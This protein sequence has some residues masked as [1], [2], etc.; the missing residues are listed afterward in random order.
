[1]TGAKR[2]AAPT[3]LK[4]RGRRFWTAAVE[5]YEFTDAE[6]ELLVEVCRTLD[7]TEQLD[8]VVRTDGLTIEGSR[9]QTVTHP[10][11][12][13]LRQARGLLSRLLAQLDLPDVDGAASLPSAFT[14]RARQGASARWGARDAG[15]A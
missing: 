11:I 14:L 4:A 8:A 7:L 2:L 9:G 3:G 13:E 15:T 6:R 12:G 5:A 10:A 1:M